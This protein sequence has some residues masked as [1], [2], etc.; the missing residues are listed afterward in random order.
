MASSVSRTGAAGDMALLVIFAAL[1]PIMS[2]LH[3]RVSSEVYQLLAG[4]LL[5]GVTALGQAL[6][7]DGFQ[8]WRAFGWEGIERTRALRLLVTLLMYPALTMLSIVIWYVG[9]AG[10]NIGIAYDLGALIGGGIM[11]WRA[12]AALAHKRKQVL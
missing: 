3:M 7:H 8:R 1:F 11:G 10:P 9:S 6:L 5:G 2:N 12:T 4:I